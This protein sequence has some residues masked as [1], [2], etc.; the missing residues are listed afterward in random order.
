MACEDIEP[1]PDIDPAGTLDP[2]LVARAKG[3][4]TAWF[5]ECETLSDWDDTV[6]LDDL[7]RRFAVALSGI[8]DRLWALAVKFE[9]CATEAKDMGFPNTAELFAIAARLCREEVMK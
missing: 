8:Q 3:I 2:A 4:V 1:D 9:T 7:S 6:A 5:S